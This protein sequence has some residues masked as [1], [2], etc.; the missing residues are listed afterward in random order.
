[1]AEERPEKIPQSRCPHTPMLEEVSSSKEACEVCGETEDL[2]LCRT[3]GFVGCCESHES[4]DEE[5]FEDT[6]HP[7][8]EPHLCDYDFLWCYECEAYLM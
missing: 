6:E 4:H 1:M 5:H 2:R 7:F 8:I 3:C